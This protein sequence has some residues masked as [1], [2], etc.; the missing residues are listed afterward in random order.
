M[1]QGSRKRTRSD[2]VAS[3]ELPPS[4]LGRLFRHAQRGDVQLRL[5][6]CVLAALATFLEHLS[7]A[8]VIERT[9]GEAPPGYF[10][11]PAWCL[12]KNAVR[13]AIDAELEQ[14]D[15]WQGS[16]HTPCNE[17]ECSEPPT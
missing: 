7:P 9:H 1:S 11:G 14:R 6:L 13:A 17:A 2:H 16:R 5:L 10:L 3:L 4:T 8:C 12:D 15:T